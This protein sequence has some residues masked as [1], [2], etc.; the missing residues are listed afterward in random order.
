[1]VL[2]LRISCQHVTSGMFVKGTIL[3]VCRRRGRLG[4]KGSSEIHLSS[5]LEKKIVQQGR[6]FHERLFQSVS[7]PC[8]EFWRA[9][10]EASDVL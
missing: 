8:R 2:K 5:S 1:M 10:S 9:N 4:N 6:E 7:T 3:C